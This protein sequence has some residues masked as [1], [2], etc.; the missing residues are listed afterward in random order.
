MK[1]LILSDSHEKLIDLDLSEY[2]YI[3]HAGD[4]GISRHLLEFNNAY[5]VAGNCD[6][7]GRDEILLTINGKKFFIT[8]GHR[9]RVRYDLTSLYL[10][11]RE[12]EADFVIYGHNHYQVYEEDRGIIFINPGAYNQNEYAVIEDGQ[13]GFYKNGI[14]ITEIYVDGMK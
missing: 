9:Y 6:F 3:I 2:D 5:F 4:Y 14:K 12:V 10:K 11:A 8:H 1:I 7:D 13:L